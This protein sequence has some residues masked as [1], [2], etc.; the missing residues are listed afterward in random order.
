MQA[1][2]IPST[3]NKFNATQVT[4]QPKTTNQTSLT[5]GKQSVFQTKKTDTVKFSQEALQKFSGIDRGI[6][7]K[8]SDNGVQKTISRFSVKA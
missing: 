6:Q 1:S 2:Q 3:L 7:K 5:Q 4:S 8:S